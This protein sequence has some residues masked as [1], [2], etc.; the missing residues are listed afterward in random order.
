[1]I[2]TEE[3]I[4]NAELINNLVGIPWKEGGMDYDGCGCVGLAKLY[5]EA[6]GIKVITE[7]SSQEII[8]K[9][10]KEEAV[11]PEDL[12]EGDTII[13]KIDGELHLGVYLGYGRFLQA[14]RNNKSHIS[15]LCP[16]LIECYQFAIRPQDGTIY[17]PPGGPPVVFAAVGAIA[18][19]FLISG[20]AWAT[21]GAFAVTGALYGAAI[22]YSIGLAMNPQKFAM[23]QS[24]PRY[25]FGELKGTATNQLPVPIIYGQIRVAGNTFYQ[26]PVEG[27]NTIEQIIGLCEGEIESITDV[28]VNG[29]AI[30]DLSGCSYIA[31]LG[32]STQNV[33]T[34]TGLD[35]DG[36][37]YRNIACLYVK[38]T[39]SE[40]LKGQPNVTCIVQGKKVNT[41]D[42]SSW[43]G[44]TYSDN[45]ATCLRD[46]LISDF[47]AGGCGLASSDLG[48]IAFGQ[49]YDR[50][51]TQ[52]SDGNGG[53]EA[54][55]TIGICLDQKQSA[56]DNISEMLPCFAGMLFRSGSTL[57]LKVKTIENSVQDFDEDDIGNF[58][59]SQFGYDDKINRFGIEYFDPNQNDAKVLV[60]GAQDHYDQEING[61]V[62]RTLTLPGVTR[63]TQAL[64]LSNQ[65]FYELRVT[66][67]QAKIT[68]ATKCIGIEPGDIIKVTHSLP[69]W[70]KKLF[71]VS[72]IDEL[73]DLSY[74]LVLVEYN[75]TIYDDSYGATIET[76]DYGSPPNPYSP[77]TDVGSVTISENV[78]T[79]KDGRAISDINVSWV[80]PTDNTIQFL[81]YYRLE[82]SKDSGD[83]IPSVTADKDKTT[84]VIPNVEAESTYT[85]KIKT[86]SINGINS[87]GTE[88]NELTTEGKTEPPAKVSNFSF[89]FTNEL[90][91]SWDKNSETDL[92]GYEIRDADTNWGVQN[93][94]LIYRGLT[95][96]FT[97]VNP[98]SRTPGTYYIR[99]FNRSN[100][101]SL[102][103]R[104]AIP[105][106]AAPIIGG[107]N[108]DV[109][110]GF[111]KASWND[112]NDSDLLYYEIYKSKTGA[113]AGEEIL[114]K[115]VP[116]T[117]TSL[118]GEAPQQG[119]ADSATN[120]T[121]VDAW[122]TKFA[123][124]YF[125]GWIIFISD[126]TGKNQGRTVSDFTKATGTFTVSDNWAVNPDSTSKFIV[127]DKKFYRIRGVDTYGAGSYSPVKSCTF[128]DL[129]EEMLQDGLIT[130]RK[131]YAEDVITL[132]AQIRD[133]VITNAKIH[134]LS[135]DKINAG[136]IIVP[137]TSNPDRPIKSESI[138]LSNNQLRIY[139][140]NENLRVLL[141]NLTIS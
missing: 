76:F 67:L 127:T 81:D 133:A 59:Y 15:R 30:G 13:F 41:W 20:P 34:D 66:N 65:Y 87:S 27:G 69:D 88:S 112:S 75:P 95:N 86:I 74:A 64:R 96:K 131:V 115:R 31:F 135:A 68:S 129:T 50:C 138:Q 79:D 104:T 97:I 7:L 46:Y 33:Q 8:K 126:G 57:K 70:T 47:E 100:I 58:S 83:Y 56:I 17:L 2:T 62:E 61:I 35:L 32:T 139:D 38:L 85:I 106:N 124:D 84:A 123:D 44:S 24:S 107:F 63:K 52:I 140:E 120:N 109:Y 54:R 29:I 78:Y 117:S 130:G 114:E 141:G 53:S 25:S 60:W 92:S 12:Q 103:S 10:L 48:S 5:Y 132:T 77:V 80:A 90:A 1:M 91:F 118:Y 136:T 105:V 21:I 22:G 26:N 98:G 111:A 51:A 89:V 45:P 121:L 16:E 102:G 23:D 128:T 116:G 71:M 39:A 110:F 99:A 82:Y 42:G 94:N 72:E 137:V 119:T 113:F 122:F 6:K 19:G 93:A 108:I 49:S 43:A 55:Y 134:D 125:N 18:G 36:V 40:Q 4:S 73:S 9:T 11:A 101:F 28:R 14:E 37:Q 3:R